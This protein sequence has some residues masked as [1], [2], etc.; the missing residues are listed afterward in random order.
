MSKG[1]VEELRGS[2][3]KTF[4]TGAICGALLVIGLQ[5]CSSEAPKGTKPKPAPTKTA[6][7][8]QGAS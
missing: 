1:D 7:V 5:S 3:V 8:R 2:G 4:V 6:T